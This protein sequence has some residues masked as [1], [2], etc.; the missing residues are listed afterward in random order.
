MNRDDAPDWKIDYHVMYGRT[1]SDRPKEVRPLNRNTFEYRVKDMLFANPNLSTERIMEK[2]DLKTN[3][4]LLRVMNVR[5]EYLHTV[6][7]LIRQGAT[8]VKGRERRP[9][10]RR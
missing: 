10:R 5:S 8:G 3:S 1:T 7:F 6:D 9:G 4:A 2:L